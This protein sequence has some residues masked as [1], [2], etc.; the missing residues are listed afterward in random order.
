MPRVEWGSRAVPRRFD[1]GLVGTF[2]Q[3]RAAFSR[4]AP[5]QSAARRR[6]SQPHPEPA[7][8]V[9]RAVAPRHEL[10]RA[11]RAGHRGMTAWHTAVRRAASPGRP[12]AAARRASAGP[13]IPTPRMSRR[14]RS[15]GRHE[16]GGATNYLDRPWER[17]PGPISRTHPALLP[18]QAARFGFN[19]WLLAS[20][21]LHDASDWLWDTTTTSAVRRSGSWKSTWRTTYELGRTCTLVSKGRKELQ[22]AARKGRA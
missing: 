22:G 14:G 20:R 9:R 11:R 10:R 12:P 5:P 3:A 8:G 15:L 2:L 19:G 1:G 21:H 13:G 18:R 7:R 4:S 6:R 16:T 17:S